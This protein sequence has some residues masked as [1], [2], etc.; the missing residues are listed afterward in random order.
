MFWFKKKS[1]KG[2][3]FLEGATDIHCHLLAGVDDGFETL[4]DSY[5]L[6]AQQQNAGL[7]RVYLTPHSMGLEGAVVDRETRP[8]HQHHHS[9]QPQTEA[10]GAIEDNGLVS[11]AVLMARNEA[12]YKESAKS[13][14]YASE[15]LGGYSNAHLKERF[16]EYRK[17][18][19]GGVELR[20]AAEYMM[21]KEFLAKVQQ[22]DLLTYA[23]GTHVLV[24]TSYFAPPV[25]MT[26]ILYSLAVS[27]YKPI[28]AHPERYHYMT[29]ADY[30][31]LKSTGYEFQLNYLSLT[32]YYGE[33][34][35]ERA[36][37]LLDNGLYSFTGS[38]YH[39]ISTF[40]HLMPHFKLS[41]KR[42]DKLLKLFENNGTI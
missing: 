40:Y 39:R 12:S 5:E 28:I 6:L 30:R 11:S 23:D 17:Y 16:E 20:L 41:A 31:R 27:G 33:D 22:K 19:T 1:K 8:H 15:P 10:E 4:S 13:S 32:G 34:A 3:K 14:Q 38:D 9:A 21:N 24:E 18:Y 37:D 42:A 36:I 29:K 26:E 7:K 2:L 25:D 35:Y